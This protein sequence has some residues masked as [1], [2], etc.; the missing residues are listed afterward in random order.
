MI[1][2]EEAEKLARSTVESYINSCCCGN[3]QDVA[4]ALMKLASMCGLAMCAVV[5]Q[6]EAVARI[7]SVGKHISKSKFSGPWITERSSSH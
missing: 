5:G 1:T 6:D 7:E 4:N 3:N 2:P